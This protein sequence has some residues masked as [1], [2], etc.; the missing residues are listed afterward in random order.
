[1]NAYQ[2]EK[3]I[4]FLILGVKG[5]KDQKLMDLH[6]LN[7]KMFMLAI[8]TQNLECNSLVSFPG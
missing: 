6:N 8:C 1:M 2:T 3:R 5:L 4:E 7:A